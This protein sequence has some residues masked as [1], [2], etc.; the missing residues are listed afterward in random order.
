MQQCLSAAAA[1]RQALAV[2]RHADAEPTERARDLHADPGGPD[3][4]RGPQMGVPVRQHDNWGGH[5]H[6]ARQLL[7]WQCQAMEGAYSHQVR[8]QAHCSAACRS[9]SALLAVHTSSMSTEGEG[10]AAPVLPF[11][12]MVAALALLA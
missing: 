4:T 6:R 9:S 2:C 11:L 3:L 10:C 8:L 5:R 12:I 1:D 7:P